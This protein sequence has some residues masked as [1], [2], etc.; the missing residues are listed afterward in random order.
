MENIES[1]DLRKIKEML[2]SLSQKQSDN[3]IMLKAI[4]KTLSQLN[5][6][7][8]GNPQYGLKGIINEISDLKEYVQ[9]DRTFKNK[10]IGGLLVVGTVWTA[11]LQ[12]LFRLFTHK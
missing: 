7:V 8:I 10:M 3:D 5:Q 2:E 9:N 4:D 1:Q 11:L 12:Y 6:T